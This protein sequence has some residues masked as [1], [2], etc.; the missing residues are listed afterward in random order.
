MTQNR[1]DQSIEKARKFRRNETRSMHHRKYISKKK[2]S[3]KPIDSKFIISIRIKLLFP[4]S[5]SEKL[6]ETASYRNEIYANGVLFLKSHSRFLSVT[7]ISPETRQE[8]YRYQREGGSVQ[9]Y[10]K[11]ESIIEVEDIFVRIYHCTG[12]RE[13]VQKYVRIPRHNFCLNYW[14]NR[15]HSIFLLHT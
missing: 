3:F 11:H 9:Y 14:R 12:N 6:S 4:R 1:I 13:A 8:Y 2:V 7:N 5:E 10:W 15:C